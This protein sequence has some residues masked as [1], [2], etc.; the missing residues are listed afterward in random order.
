MENTRDAFDRAL[1]YAIDGI[2]TDVQLT[3]DE[4]AVLW[5]DRFL[6]K[7]GYPDRRID[8]FDYTQLQAL[9]PPCGGETIMTLSDFL[10]R[11]RERCQL[12]VE[13]KNRDWE[14]IE[15]HRIKM[16]LTLDLIGTNSDRYIAVSSFNLNS[17]CYAHQYRPGFP[18]IYNVEP[19]Q[20][21]DDVRA[22]LA[23][24]G[25]L[26]GFCLPIANTDQA[27]VELLQ[28]HGKCVGVY[29]CNSDAEINHALRSGVD[30]L[31]SDVPDQA[32]RLRDR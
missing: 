22:L 19:D 4:V 25:F 9:V 16:R 5:H 31:I 18:L 28:R 13:I 26:H 10:A 14:S 7:I 27:I 30:I 24:H 6:N 2:E 15:R 29:T 1:Y 21:V 23:T 11:Y 12:L 20:T 32:L 3:R 8:D 17:L